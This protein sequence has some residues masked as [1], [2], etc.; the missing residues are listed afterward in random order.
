M[1]NKSMDENL[2]IKS[3]AMAL[4]T[5]SPQKNLS[6]NIKSLKDNLERIESGELNNINEILLS[7]ASV[8]NNIFTSLAI[9][10]SPNSGLPL[11]AQE[12]YLRLALKAQSQCCASLR[13]L[14][15]I[16]NPALI[17]HNH[18]QYQQVK[19]TIEQTN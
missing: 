2:A 1:Y 5:Y 12:K 6:E 9:R 11:A 14:V 13:A 3:N 19:T 10:A 4:L 17:Q 8:L 18:A 15:D 7:Q 16:K